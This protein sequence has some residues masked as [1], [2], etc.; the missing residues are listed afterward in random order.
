MRTT[1]QLS[2]AKADEFFVVRIRAGA[3]HAPVAQLVGQRV[4]TPIS[5]STQ[6]GSGVFSDSPEKHDTLRVTAVVLP[7]LPDEAG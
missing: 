2:V 1:E 3:P 4:A 5:D 6:N 7:G